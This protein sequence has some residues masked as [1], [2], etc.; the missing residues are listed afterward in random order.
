MVEINVRIL[1]PLVAGKAGGHEAFVQLRYLRNTDSV[2]VELR[3]SSLLRGKQFVARGIIDNP[4]N[5][6]ALCVGRSALGS[7]GH[8]EHRK[9]MREVRGA[10]ERI[11]VPAIV[12]ALVV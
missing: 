3:A 4:G 10:I 11:D 9:S 7:H 8:T 5:A 12:A 1:M 6:N 2:A